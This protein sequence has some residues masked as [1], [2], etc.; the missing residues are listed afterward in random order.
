MD[1]A[2]DPVLLEL[3]NDIDDAGITQVRGQFSL[4]VSPKTNT[5]ASFDRLPRWVMSLITCFTT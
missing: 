5:R 1:V 4:K 2:L 3:G